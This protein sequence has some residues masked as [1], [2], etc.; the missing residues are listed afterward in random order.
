LF[1]Q[2]RTTNNNNKKHTK[3]K[4]TRE[5]RKK[6]ENRNIEENLESRKTSG[7]HQFTGSQKTV[8][9]LMLIA[10]SGEQSGRQILFAG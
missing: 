1:E 7:N 2:E 8:C 10:W 5:K 3:T 9:I 4:E 6:K